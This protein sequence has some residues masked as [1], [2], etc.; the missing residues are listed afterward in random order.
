MLDIK[1]FDKISGVDT[2]LYFD[3]SEFE[4]PSHFARMPYPHYLA[5][6]VQLLSLSTP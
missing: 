6:G 5:E 1:T 2:Y 3:L 4:L